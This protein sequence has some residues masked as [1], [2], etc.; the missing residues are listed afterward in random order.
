MNR[1]LDTL[2]RAGHAVLDEQNASLIVFARA[3]LAG[4][5]WAPRDEPVL[6]PMQVESVRPTAN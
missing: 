6:R 4:G 1:I 3:P 2:L 5:C